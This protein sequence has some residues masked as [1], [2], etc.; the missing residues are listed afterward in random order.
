[1]CWRAAYQSTQPRSTLENKTQTGKSVFVSV[2]LRRELGLTWPTMGSRRCD[3]P[4][5]GRQQDGLHAIRGTAGP[6]LSHNTNNSQPRCLILGQ[7]YKAPSYLELFAHRSGVDPLWFSSEIRDGSLP[8]LPVLTQM[9]SRCHSLFSGS[10]WVH[11][12]E[13]S[14]WIPVS[15]LSFHSIHSV[16]LLSLQCKVQQGNTPHLG[17][18]P[19]LLD[20][21]SMLALNHLLLEHWA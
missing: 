1:M 4:S 17:I 9:G 19:W 2:L 16:G 12:K 20:Q 15:Q 8:S 18:H 10:P 6:K 11:C 13:P 3:P 7:V 21:P 14:K 5:E